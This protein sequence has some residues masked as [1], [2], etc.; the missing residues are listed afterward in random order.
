MNLS[1]DSE[2]FF[3]VE[4]NVSRGFYFIWTPPNID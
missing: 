1:C 2:K 3:F 4:T